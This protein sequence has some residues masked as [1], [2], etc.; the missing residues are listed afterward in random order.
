MLGMTLVYDSAEDA[1][2]AV[3][4]FK[5]DNRVTAGTPSKSRES[6]TELYSVYSGALSSGAT[7][8]SNPEIA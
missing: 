1:L 7:V 4:V 3:A 6:R 8:S 2:V 5:D